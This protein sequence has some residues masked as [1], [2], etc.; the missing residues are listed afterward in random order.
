L[1]FD[2]SGV[3][4]AAFG[5]EDRWQDLRLSP[6]GKR[7]AVV[8]S[9]ENGNRDIW[10]M[11]LASGLPRRWSSHPATDWRPVWD[12]ESRSLLFASDRN[13]AS[14]IFRRNADARDHDHL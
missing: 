4:R 1:A 7:A 2:R 5:T 3:Q 11:D 13:G 10:L 12:P 9:D 8:K 14:A 6:D